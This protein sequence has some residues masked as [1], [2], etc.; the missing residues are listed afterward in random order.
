MRNALD[1]LGCF[2]ESVARF[3]ISEVI[4]GLE[5]LHSLNIIHRDLKPEN[6]LLN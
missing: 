6:L 1:D 4:L 5:S 2:D 3:Y